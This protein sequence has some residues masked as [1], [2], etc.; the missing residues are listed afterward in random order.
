MTKTEVAKLVA[1]AVVGFSTSKVVRMIVNNNVDPESVTDQVAVLVASHVLGAIAADAAKE[2][3]D[4][5]IDKLVELWKKNVK[6]V[7]SSTV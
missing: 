7:K 3:T 4:E 1:S 2:W 6:Q 5:Q